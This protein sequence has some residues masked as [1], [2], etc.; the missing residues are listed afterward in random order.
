MMMAQAMTVSMGDGELK[1]EISEAIETNGCNI[2]ITHFEWWAVTK[3][4]LSYKEVRVI[5]K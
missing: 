1:R 3:P 2:K 4:A 5:L